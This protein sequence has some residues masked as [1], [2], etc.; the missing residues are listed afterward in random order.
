MA[1]YLLLLHGGKFDVSPDEMKEIS[2]IGRA[3]V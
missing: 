3:H 2:K 1:E